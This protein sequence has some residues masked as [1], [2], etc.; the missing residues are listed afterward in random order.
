MRGIT[1]GG[2]LALLL[3]ALPATAG[4]EHVAETPSAE[5]AF[6]RLKGLEG[7]WTGK[8]AVADAEHEGTPVVHEFRV[9]ANGSV[10]METMNPGTEHEMI[11][12]YHLDG[13]A[14]VL[15]HYCAGSNQPTMKLDRSASGADAYVFEFTGGTNLDPAKDQ[16]IHDAKLVFHE[17]GAL[18][19][20]WSGWKD[21][22]QQGQMS[23]L[24][25]RSGS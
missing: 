17:D 6:E 8:I 13:D 12:M 22:E 19:S 20:N 5:A 7:T 25:A 3:T 1:A 16:H 15:T 11:N 14:L 23:F 4:E 10:V 24:L 9:S 2:V 18:E 21:G